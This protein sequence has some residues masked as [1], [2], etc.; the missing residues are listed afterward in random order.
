L[1][2]GL[3]KP[4]CNPFLPYSHHVSNTKTKRIQ[5]RA[6]QFTTSTCCL[7][8]RHF[9]LS[10]I[11]FSVVSSIVR[12]PALAPV[13]RLYYSL[14]CEAKKSVLIY[15]C[16]PA[17]PVYAFYPC[18]PRV[19]YSFQSICVCHAPHPGRPSPVAG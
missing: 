17:L 7:H 6:G 13:F 3:I 14:L 8:R 5:G 2:S 10:V 4:C 19:S 1:C 9:D 15:T 16:N 12:Y 11:R 18:F